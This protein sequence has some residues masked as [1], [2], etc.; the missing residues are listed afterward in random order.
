MTQQRHNFRR[1]GFTLI[2]LLVAMAMVA[3]LAGVLYP[4]MRTA[5]NS[6][7][8]ATNSLEPARS[9]DIAMDLI[10]QDL[11]GALQ[12]TAAEV[13][14]TAANSTSVLVGT[15]E[16]VNAAGGASADDLTFYTT[17]YASL[18]VDANGDVKEVELTVETLP[19]TNEQVLVRRVTANL[20]SS[21]TVTPDEEILCRNV[22]GFSLRYFDGS[23]WNDS[24]DSTQE[25]NTIPAAVEV[26]IQ[27]TRP[28]ALGVPEKI[29]PFVRVY[30]LPCSTAAQDTNVNGGG[31][32][33]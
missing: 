18:H 32:S 25:D 11:Q 23:Q 17:S 33:L 26:T 10:G 8:T 28:S 16:G 30:Q 22:A 15:F 3:A 12:Q 13:T 2:E 24:W 14:A 5:F 29:P 7:A 6:Q 31:A 9:V 19:G 4:A 1:G 21:T 20:L 27:L